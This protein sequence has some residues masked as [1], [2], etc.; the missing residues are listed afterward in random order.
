[1]EVE[2][3]LE[4]D[5]RAVN[6]AHKRK[7]HHYVDQPNVEQMKRERRRRCWEV[8]E[9][10]SDVVLLLAAVVEMLAFLGILILVG[11]IKKGLGL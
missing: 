7:L 6:A 10:I 1:M 9:H 8:F 3:Q 11:L 5:L 2:K 4:E